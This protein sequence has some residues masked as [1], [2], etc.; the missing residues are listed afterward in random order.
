MLKL[1]EID[2]RQDPAASVFVKHETVSV[3]FADAD[4]ELISREGPNR[5]R[6]GDALIVGSTGD[7]WSVDRTRFEQKYEALPPIRMGED[8]AYRAQPVPVLARQIGEAFCIARRAGG[9]VLQ[10]LAG[11]WVLQYAP[12]DYGVVEE[13]RFKRVYRPV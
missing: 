6:K 9:D 10:A 5:Y 8:G 12:G 7:R 1:E 2:L 11:D 3:V 4:G 13:A